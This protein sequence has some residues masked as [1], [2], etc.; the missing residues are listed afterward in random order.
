MTVNSAYESQFNI[1]KAVLLSTQGL[2]IRALFF[3]CESLAPSHSQSHT[4]H[5]Q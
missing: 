4:K 1:A 5:V 2:K 3:K